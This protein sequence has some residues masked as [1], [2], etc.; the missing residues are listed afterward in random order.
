[1]KTTIGEGRVDGIW[2]IACCR[3]RRQG[4]HRERA[5][6]GVHRHRYDRQAFGPAA[7]TDTRKCSCR[8]DG[9]SGRNRR[10]RVVP[11]VGRS[12][13]RDGADVACEWRLGNDL[14]RLRRWQSAFRDPWS[15]SCETLSCGD[16]L[17]P[18]IRRTP[19]CFAG[20]GFYGR[21]RQSSDLN[22][23]GA[24][25]RKQVLETDRREACPPERKQT[26]RTRNS[27]KNTEP[28]HR[29][30]LPPPAFNIEA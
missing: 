8:T 22:S 20:L 7:R 1:M 30:D 18:R 21:E 25:S 24:N 15:R 17:A 29:L 12:R 2:K 10:R 28:M 4:H 13:L 27:L 3:S 9:D 14:I 16:R 19:P 23:R 6:A 26:N 11:R 5:C